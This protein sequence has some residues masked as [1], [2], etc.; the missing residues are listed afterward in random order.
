MDPSIRI[1]V[2]EHRMNTFE[3]A[4]EQYAEERRRQHDRLEEKLDWIT[5]KVMYGVGAVGVLTIVAQAILH[6]LK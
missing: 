1:A 6:F 2:L 4:F 3:K 5:K